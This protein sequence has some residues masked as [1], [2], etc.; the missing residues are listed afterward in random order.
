MAGEEKSDPSDNEGL[1]GQTRREFGRFCPEKFAEFHQDRVSQILQMHK[2]VPACSKAGEKNPGLPRKIGKSSSD[3]PNDPFG[4]NFASPACSRQAKFGIIILTTIIIF[5]SAICLA[6]GENIAEK[7]QSFSISGNSADGKN[8]WQV[9]GES[10]DIFSETVNMNAIKAKSRS[11]KIN[12]TLNAD[13]GTFYRDT[14]DVE[15]RKNVVANTD[16]GTTLK[17][18]TLKWY[19]EAE[20]VTTDD[21]VQIHRNDVDISGKGAKGSPNLNKIQ[22]N[23][24]VKMTM[25]PALSASENEA[26][27]G[28]VK[29]TTVITCDGSLEV[30]YKRYI[31]YFNKNVIIEDKEG[32]IYADKV[33]AYIDPKEKKISKAIAKGNVKI[34]HKQNVSYCKKAIYLADKGKIVLIGKPRVV[35]Y[36]LDKLNEGN[37]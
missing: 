29:P 37:S 8:S 31:S 2:I 6:A 5:T 4:A 36:S 28:V 3:L 22:L 30:D 26:G 20:K 27:K 1:Q 9:E 11:D 15:L 7:V 23:S 32:K 33:I 10:A 12:V 13:E 17:T 21:Y 18:D 25:H 19:A 34:E 14:K 16:E 35:I 24:E